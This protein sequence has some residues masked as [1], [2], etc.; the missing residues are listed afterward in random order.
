MLLECNYCES[1]VDA[2]ELASYDDPPDYGDGP[3]AVFRVSL[4]T[5]PQCKNALVGGFYPDF[6]DGP[7]RMWPRPDRYLSSDI[8]AIARTSLQEAE[9]CFK[10]QAYTACAV[11]CGRSLE[12]ICHHF[13][14][15]TKMLAGGLKELLDKKIIDGR[16]FEWGEAL[17]SQR[18]IAAHASE[19]RIGKDDASDL[20]DFS[21]AICEY[22]FVLTKKYQA[23]RERQTKNSATKAK[24]NQLRDLAVS[25]ETA[26]KAD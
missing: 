4:V 8:P 3:D 12:G 22:V 11:M 24:R 21:V 7:T 5:C 17:R 9:R 15:K 2:K 6:E 18:N 20:L 26:H 10:A 1:R 25:R 16:L 23:F 19:Q 14:T 13:E